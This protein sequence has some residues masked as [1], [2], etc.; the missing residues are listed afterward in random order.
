M[1]EQILK[2]IFRQNI[3]KN[4]HSNGRF[5]GK[6]TASSLRQKKRRSWKES[7]LKPFSNQGNPLKYLTAAGPLTTINRALF[8][9]AIILTILAPLFLW[10]D[11]KVL[12]THSF[13]RQI[14][15]NGATQ[16]TEISN[17]S[18]HSFAPLAARRRYFRTNVRESVATAVDP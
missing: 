16:K 13:D 1:K 2:F 17:K 9:L 15:D 8:V 12:A 10:Y 7:F 4:H 14:D 5:N 6:H 11:S 18:S 3:E